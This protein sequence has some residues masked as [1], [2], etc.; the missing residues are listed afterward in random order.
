MHQTSHLVLMK[1]LS[2]L[3]FLTCLNPAVDVGVLVVLDALLS[4][5]G[6]DHEVE[7]LYLVTY[8]LLL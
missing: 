8:R 7:V 4:A 2:L 1:T 6:V 5:L 3:L